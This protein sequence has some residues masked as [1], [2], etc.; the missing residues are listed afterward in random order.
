MI[1]DSST[2]VEARTRAGGKIMVLARMADPKL[3]WGL[4][5]LSFQSMPDTFAGSTLFTTDLIKNGHRGNE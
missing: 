4:D 5:L 1:G 3:H 2:E